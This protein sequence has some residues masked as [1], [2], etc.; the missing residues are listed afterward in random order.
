MSTAR[1]LSI[2][3]VSAIMGSVAAS[4]GVTESGTTV[5]RATSSR[6]SNKDPN[7][8]LVIDV[9]RVEERATEKVATTKVAKHT[10]MQGIRG[11]ERLT[12]ATLKDFH[13]WRANDSASAIKFSVDKNKEA[14]FRQTTAEWLEPHIPGDPSG[15][16]SKRTVLKSR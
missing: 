11:A 14:A 1:D 5:S 8:Q 4:G 2:T 6:K 9:S 15:V 16:P 10:V 12:G 3:S 13:I 7:R